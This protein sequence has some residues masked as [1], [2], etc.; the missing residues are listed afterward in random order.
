[1][2][3]PRAWPTGAPCRA[4]AAAALALAAGDSESGAGPGGAAGPG[5]LVFLVFG[6]LVFGEC[7]FLPFSLG[8]AGDCPCRH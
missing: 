8:P 6:S 2:P 4:A 3:A 5:P 1:M 7:A